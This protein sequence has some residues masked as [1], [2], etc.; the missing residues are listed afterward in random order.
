MRA[1]IAQAGGRRRRPNADTEAKQA[2]GNPLNTIK[3][4]FLERPKGETLEA[5]LSRREADKAGG[6][7]GDSAAVGF[8]PCCFPPLTKR[9]LPLRQRDS[10]PQ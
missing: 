4:G 1:R 7:G 6:V 9:P 8:A 2:K 10:P 5:L 3:I